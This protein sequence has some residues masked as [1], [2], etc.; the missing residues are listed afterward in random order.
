MSPVDDEP[1]RPAASERRRGFSSRPSSPRRSRSTCPYA[2]RR[3]SSGSCSR[4]ALIFAGR[5]SPSEY[6][7][8]LRICP[9]S[10][11]VHAASRSRALCRSTQRAM[12]RLRPSS[13]TRAS[14]PDCRKIPSRIWCEGSWSWR[15]RRRCSSAPTCSRA[16]TSPCGKPWRL[17]G[18]ALGPGI[19][20]SGGRF[21]RPVISSRA[22]GPAYASSCSPYS[23]AGSAP[24]AGP[25]SGRPST[26]PW[27]NLWVRILSASFR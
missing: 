10:L 2:S 24:A 14:R 15:F 9:P 27:R 21:S 12:R 6:G 20:D 7:L 13:G 8:D 18:A 11:R 1:S 25:C 26:T 16:G 22:T 19:V 17:F 4:S 3:R 5:R 23:P